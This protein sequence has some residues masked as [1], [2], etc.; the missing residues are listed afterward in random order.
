ML[1]LKN[2]PKFHIVKK[3]WNNIK[4]NPKIEVKHKILLG[5]VMLTGCRISEILKIKRE[6]IDFEKS[7]L[8]I[9]QSKK[10]KE[11]YREVI[12]PKDL[13]ELIEVNKWWNG[14]NFTRQNAFYVVKKWTKYHPHAFRHSFAIEV[15]SKTK[16]MEL[17]RRLLG[18]SNYNVIKFYLD[19]TVEDIKEEVAKI[20]E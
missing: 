16:N 18:H 13:L 4:N 19:F 10:R 11:T 2:V 7:T 20:Y 9:K 1:K 6:D 8:K 3:L 12:V 15:L 17:V 14:F 5:F